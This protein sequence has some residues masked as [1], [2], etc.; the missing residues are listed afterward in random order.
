VRVGAGYEEV[1]VGRRV[2][3]D[4]ESWEA[5]DEKALSVGTREGAELSSAVDCVAWV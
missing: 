5:V 1:W 4:W 2:D 3:V